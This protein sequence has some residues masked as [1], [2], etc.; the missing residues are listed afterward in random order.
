MWGLVAVGTPEAR[1]IIKQA[2]RSML[3]GLKRAAQA[4]LNQMGMDV[5]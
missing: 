5:D 1:E 3:P 2:G 4:V